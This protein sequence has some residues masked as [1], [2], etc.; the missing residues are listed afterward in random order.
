MI[1]KFQQ[2]CTLDA[3]TSFLKGSIHLQLTGSQQNPVTYRRRPRFDFV[4]DGL[5]EDAKR[6][7]T[8][9]QAATQ[10]NINEGL[11][12]PEGE[13]EPHHAQPGDHLFKGSDGKYEEYEEEKYEE[14]EEEEGRQGGRKRDNSGGLAERRREEEGLDL[15][16]G[17]SQVGLETVQSIEKIAVRQGRRRRPRPPV[18]HQNEMTAAM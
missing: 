17:H 12:H 10:D 2:L 7:L 4:H 18:L 16:Q 1:Y 11:V 6:V 5:S 13:D 3:S 15:E 14:Y 9:L 8:S